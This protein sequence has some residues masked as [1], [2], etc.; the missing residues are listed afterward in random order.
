M[1]KKLQPKVVVAENVKGILLGNA[2][3]Y[4][5]EIYKEF[6]K[7][8]YYCQHFLLNASKM[9]VPQKRER[10]FFICLR[11]DLAEPFIEQVDLFLERPRLD[12]EFN[13]EPILWGEIYRK[14]E[15]GERAL[16]EG[17]ELKRLWGLKKP[18]DKSLVD[19][20]KR[21]FG[22]EKF[23]ST[24]LLHKGD[25]SLT[26]PSN[27]DVLVLFDEPRRPNQ[28]EICS[29]ASFPQDYNFLNQKY[30]YVCGMSVPPIMMHRVA[31]QVFNQWLSKIN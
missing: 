11:K 24:K 7:A 19:T 28:R 30:N 31:E 22:V 21:E 25:V 20:A 3:K 26:M 16:N 5:Q 10:V 8:G 18:S 4:V 12:L 6:D 15:G 9:G 1:A 13:E 2:V 29:L 17:T 23:F 27:D 14:G